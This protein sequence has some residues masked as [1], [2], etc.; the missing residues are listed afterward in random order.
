M[1]SVGSCSPRKL[2]IAFN[3]L[4][5][6]DEDLQDLARGVADDVEEGGEDEIGEQSPAVEQPSQMPPCFSQSSQ[7][8]KS[9]QGS[10]TPSPGGKKAAL[11]A[12]MQV[13]GSGYEH[14]D[15]SKGMKGLK[16]MKTLAPEGRKAPVVA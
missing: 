1:K 10:T 4:A 7:G 5:K 6:C 14:L 3:L 2:Q 16:G 13:N 11:I 8:S 9:A 12:A 15:A